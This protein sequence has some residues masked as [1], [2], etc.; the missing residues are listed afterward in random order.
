MNWFRD[1]DLEDG[2][3]R[4]N[5]APDRAVSRFLS[6]VA[7]ASGLGALLAFAFWGVMV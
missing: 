1:H 3:V 6:D 2:I 5:R 4:A 7:I